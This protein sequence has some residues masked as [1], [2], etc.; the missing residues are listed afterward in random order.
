MKGTIEEILGVIFISVGIIAGGL[1]LNQ[2][3]PW[4]VLVGIGLVYI[5]GIEFGRNLNPPKSK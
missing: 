4:V 1:Q 5:G 3:E 2:W